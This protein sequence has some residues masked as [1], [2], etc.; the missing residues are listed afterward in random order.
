[1]KEII[2]NNQTIEKV[3]EKDP[4]YGR[5]MDSTY[6]NFLKILHRSPIL[7]KTLKDELKGESVYQAK[8]PK[9]ILKLLKKGDY[10]KVLKKDSGL[11]NGM[12]RKKDGTKPIIKQTDWEEIQL[13]SNTLSNLNQLAIHSSISEISDQLLLMDKKLDLILVNQHT[14]RVSSI[15]SGIELYEQ[16]D[17]YKDVTRR[18]NLL[19][20]ALQ[21][22]NEGRSALFGELDSI[23]NIEKRDFH[24]TDYLWKLIRVEKAEVELFDRLDSERLNIEESIRY[25]NLATVYIF[26]IHALLNEFDA[27]DH[28]KYQF[29]KFCELVIGKITEDS[30]HPYELAQNT[31]RFKELSAFTEKA[32]SA[33]FDLIVEVKYEDLK[34]E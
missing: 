20:N 19:A 4:L 7:I 17:K 26:R 14:D 27:A 1:M 3:K 11:W 25:I 16:A 12:I 30:I 2:L 32:C 34:N 8:I 10:E 22:L 23:L 5:S 18:D 9:D 15:R 21:S 29:I 31:E 13:N 28:S 6:R 33:D 24:W